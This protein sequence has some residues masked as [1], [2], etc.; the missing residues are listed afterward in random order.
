MPSFILLHAAPSSGT[1]KPLRACRVSSAG[2]SSVSLFSYLTL[3][4][5]TLSFCVSHAVAFD[6]PHLQPAAVAEPL[7]RLTKLNAIHGFGFE[8]ALERAI[9]ESAHLGM[10]TDV[11]HIAVMPGSIEHPSAIK[12]SCYKWA[13]RDFKPWG[14]RLP[15]QCPQCGTI[16][17]W[18]RLTLQDLSYRFECGYERCGAGERGSYW[19]MVRRP[20]PLA[21]VPFGKGSGS[22]WIKLS[23]QQAIQ[24]S[25]RA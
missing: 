2:K 13:H 20:E 19:L 7:A 11:V 18:R 3:C 12:V 23:D 10:H 14:H 15:I 17:K 6:A 8:E 9:G 16:Q 24:F 4:F 1:G 22:C 5:I 21:V 25:G